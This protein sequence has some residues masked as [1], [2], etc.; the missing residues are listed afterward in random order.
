LKQYTSLKICV[1]EDTEASPVINEVKMLQR[2]GKFAQEADHPGLEFTRLASDIFEI[3]GPSGRHCCI[4]TK[5]QGT[6]LRTLQ[7]TFPNAILPKILVKSLIH[8]LWFSVNWLHATC[9]VVH[10][11]RLYINKSLYLRLSTN[12]IADISPQNV[13]MKAEDEMNFKGLED[14][15]LQNPSIPIIDDGA[16]VYQSRITMLELSGIPVLNDFGQMRLV[17]PMNKDW[18]MSDLYRAPEVLLKL[19]W[20]FPVDVWTVGVMTLELL[21]GKTLFNPIDHIH[22]QYVLPLALAQYISYLGPPPLDLIKQS[23]LLSTYFDE[24]GVQN[25]D[26]Y[27]GENRDQWLQDNGEDVLKNL[28]ELKFFEWT[29][30]FDMMVVKMLDQWP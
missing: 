19:P 24:E 16:P 18:W 12:Y 11:G 29:R 27:E 22:N 9:G 28:F 20:G 3:E 15:E 2:L 26:T 23:P 21:E 4:A 10:T 1:C 5:A 8:R 25:R 14:Q 13:L 30:S 7:E 6:S 17:E